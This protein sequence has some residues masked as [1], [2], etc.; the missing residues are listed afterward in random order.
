MPHPERNHSKQKISQDQ[1]KGEP[2]ALKLPGVVHKNKDESMTRND[3]FRELLREITTEFQLTQMQVARLLGC[4]PEHVSWVVHDH[5]NVSQ[6]IVN[7]LQNLLKMMRSAKNA[8]QGY[9]HALLSAI[10]KALDSIQPEQ[11]Q[12]ALKKLAPFLE[13]L[14]ALSTSRSR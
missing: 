13:R 5:K 12:R 8:K 9:K 14:E 10:D 6:V 7:S 4:S 11:Q 2:K 3:Q 1:G